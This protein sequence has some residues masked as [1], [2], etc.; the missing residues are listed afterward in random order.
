MTRKLVKMEERSRLLWHPKLDIVREIDEDHV[1]NPSI[2]SYGHP[3]FCRRPCIQFA[4]GSCRKGKSCGFCHLLHEVKVATF[5][6]HQRQFMKVLD[7][8]EFLRMILPHVE[9]HVKLI[10]VNEAQELLQL[11]QRE[12][13][14]RK[15]PNLSKTSRKLTHVLERMSLPQLV[16]L[17]CAKNMKGRTALLASEILKDM[18]SE[19]RFLQEEVL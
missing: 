14:I 6:S 2:G 1:E 3:D 4:R 8:A 10:E 13:A 16:G 15:A 18:R 19:V 7:E 17:I 9:K 5:D 11:I 12:L